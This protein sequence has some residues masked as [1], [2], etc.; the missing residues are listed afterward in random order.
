M[1]D[2]FAAGDTVELKSGG[3]TMTIDW[4]GPQ[5][6]GSS[7]PGGMCAWFDQKMNPQHKWFPLTSLKK[8][9]A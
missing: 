3:P 8:V 1:A 7:T 4:I 6:E 5:F 9:A 2:G